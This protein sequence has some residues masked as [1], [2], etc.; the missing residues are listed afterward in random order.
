MPDPLAGR[1]LLLL[2]VLV[3]SAAFIVATGWRDLVDLLI[4]ACGGGY[5]SCVSGDQPSG[6]SLYGAAFGVV[7]W[8]AMLRWGT[9]R[10]AVRVVARTVIILGTGLIAAHYLDLWIFGTHNIR[11]LSC[12]AGPDGICRN[13]FWPLPLPAAALGLFVGAAV[14][15][16][17]IPPRLAFKPQ[18]RG[19]A[20]GDATARSADR[21]SER[22]EALVTTAIVVAAIGATLMSLY[23][24]Q[25]DRV[26]GPGSSEVLV[27]GQPIP[28]GTSADQ[29]LEDNLIETKF[30]L[31]ED[32]IDG[33]IG[34]IRV[35]RWQVAVVDIVPG[36]QLSTQLFA[37]CSWRSPAVRGE[38]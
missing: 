25:P 38:G 16:A 2:P 17:L 33:A 18:P 4:P 3:G 30:V 13:Y 28:A 9:T 29:A 23:A 32:I 14:A 34:D 37:C 15:L 26:G 8:L 21:A 5:A 27:A 19:L 35:L 20:G 24:T 31:H 11:M 12:P 36:E 10:A 6:L 7:L 1:A 22:L